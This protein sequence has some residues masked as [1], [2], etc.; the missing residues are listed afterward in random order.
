MNEQPTL[1]ELQ[2]RWENVLVLTEQAVAGQMGRYAE[3]KAKAREVV[4]NPVDIKEYFPTAQSLAT[5]LRQLDADSRGTIFHLFGE[6]ISPSSIWQVNLL[7]VECRDLLDH[8]KV[9]DE[10]RLK[11]R[12]LHI[13]R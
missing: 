12:G 3:L 9:F 6:R 13:V 2:Q 11:S 4:S 10:W 8:L 1:A 7:R 5:L